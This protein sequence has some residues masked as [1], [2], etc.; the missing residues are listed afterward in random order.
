MENLE[1]YE[2]LVAAFPDVQRKGKT[3]PYTSANGHMFSFMTKE[4]PLA[5]RLPKDEQERFM[6]EYGT[7][8]VVQYGAVMRGYVLVPDALLAETA[9]V[10]PY[11]EK[12]LAYVLSLK[13]KP[14]KRKPTK[15]KTA[16]KK[17]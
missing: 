11:F 16:K 10:K 9:K 6:E 17:S 4:G 7:G 2:K 15:K 14:T 13:P 12:S 8:P 1:L 5:L 3:M